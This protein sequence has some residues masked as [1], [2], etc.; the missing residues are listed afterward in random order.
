MRSLD[1]AL[2][3][4]LST[5]PGLERLIGTRIYPD[6]LPQNVVYPAI[7]YELEQERVDMVQTGPSGLRESTYRFYMYAVTAE[8]TEDIE[9]Q[10]ALALFAYTDLGSPP[11]V[12][13]LKA[14]GLEGDRGFDSD[15]MAFY[16]LARFTIWWNKD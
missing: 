8:E 10:L 2:F 15:T 6:L 1:V 9:E 7:S 4:Y 3:Q 11:T 16:R 5:H 14:S 12:P 13:Y